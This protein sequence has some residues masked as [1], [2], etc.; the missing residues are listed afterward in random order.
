MLTFAITSLFA[1]SLFGALSVIGYMF[2]TYRGKIASVIRQGLE[3]PAAETSTITSACKVRV[4]S[5][6][7]SGMPVRVQ[8]RSPRPA[9][10]AVAA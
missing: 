5:T 2:V 10:L 9:P 8:N 7:V 4:T 6:R 1:L 3:L